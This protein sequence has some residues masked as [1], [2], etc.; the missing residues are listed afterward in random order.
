MFRLETDR[1][2]IRPWTDDDRGDFRTMM[3]D[4]AVT[5]YLWRAGRPYADAEV[6]EWFAR[7]ARQLA[8]FDVCMGAVIEKSTGRLL[9]LS[10][11]QPLGTTGD[12]EIGWIFRRDAWGH[13][14]ATEAGGAAMRHVLETLA[15]PR[16][17]AIIDPDNEPSKRVAARLGM[18][19]ERRYTGV[20][21]GYRKPEV[22]VDLFFKV[23]PGL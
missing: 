15:R 23:V 9:G 5:H 2:V 16:V 4:P 13:G 10:G 21:L 18:Q 20:E 3:D 12:L 7:Q 22:V 14:Y 8:E 11:T 19:Y 1:L 17:V 6:D